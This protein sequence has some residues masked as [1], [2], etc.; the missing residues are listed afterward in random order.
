LTGW[1][2]VQFAFAVKASLS[3]W[4]AP[5][6]LSASIWAMLYRL[7]ATPVVNTL[8]WQSSHL[9][10]ATWSLWLKGVAPA[11]RTWMTSSGEEKWHRPQFPVTA[12]A[13]LLL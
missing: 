12:N 3:L 11:S 10:W 5:H 8:L 2:R 6:D 4:H 13:S 9:Y 1:Q 7:A